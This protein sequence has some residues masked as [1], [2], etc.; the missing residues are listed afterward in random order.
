MGRIVS[1]E[2]RAKRSALLAAALALMLAV[3][4]A[5]ASAHF[6]PGCKKRPCKRHVVGPYKPRLLRMATC[7]SGRRWHI[8][9]VH[10]GGLQF[11][12]ATWSQT[13]S[14]FA[15]AHHA[16]ALE[17]MYRAVVWASRIGWAWR[18]TAGWPNCG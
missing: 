12:P 18:S 16:P 1:L 5:G 7:E 17:Q 15:R 6:T 13:G 9:G 8:T 3:L 14:R 2:L 11:S 4:P 10:D